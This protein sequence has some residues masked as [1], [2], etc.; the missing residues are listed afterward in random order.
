MRKTIASMIGGAILAGAIAT[1]YATIGQPPLPATG[2]GLV[3]GTWLNGLAGG[4][5]VLGVFGV[6]STGVT[7]ATASQLSQGF[8][9]YQVDTAPTSNGGVNLPLCAA[10]LDVTVINNSSNTLLVWPSLLVNSLTSTQDTLDGVN[11]AG[12][13]INILVTSAAE[14]YCAKNGKWFH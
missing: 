14:F 6:T 3:D 12:G 8:R 7:S 9:L 11:S 2:P 1:A 4:A 10:G 13:A 5:N